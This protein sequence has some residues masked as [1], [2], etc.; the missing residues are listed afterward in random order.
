MAATRY[1]AAGSTDLAS[2]GTIETGDDIHLLGG[3]AVMVTNMDQAALVTPL[4]SLEIPSQFNGSFGTAAVPHKGGYSS[5]VEY[6]ATGGDAYF[7]SQNNSTT[8]DT[9][10]LIMPQGTGG[11]FH[12]QESGTI[13][14]AE[15]AGGS[16]T[17]AAACVVTNLYMGAAA[18]VRLYDSAS[19]DP[20][21]I[22]QAGGSLYLDRG[23]TTLNVS[24]GNCWVQGVAA[25]AITTLT[26]TGG[27][28]WLVESGTITTINCWNSI[29][30]CTKLVRPITISNTSINMS[31][32][33]AAEAFLS[34]PLITH[35][36]VTQYMGR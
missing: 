26:L 14:S 36:S 5:F 27:T 1:I 29:P 13:T 4:L 30:N 15:I 24:G 19:T 8:Y 3:S 21:L 28:V 17:V 33:A 32:G 23:A 35:S 18:N 22:Q 16:F 31:L 20:T 10:Q 11:H 34:H 7:T 25:N 9:V 6:A 12:F 2:A